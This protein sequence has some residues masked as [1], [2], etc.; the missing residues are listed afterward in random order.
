M[1]GEPSLFN[2]SS[3]KLKEFKVFLF[4]YVDDMVVTRSDEDQVELVMTKLGNEFVGRRL[5]DLSYFLGIYVWKIDEGL[6]LNQ[7][8][9]LVN[10]LKGAEFDNLKPSSTPMLPNQDLFSKEEPISQAKEYRYIIG[11]L[12]YLT[13]TRFN[14]QFA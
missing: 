1:M 9:Y 11:L 4:F 12:Q 8:Q 10:L 7:Q 2:L 6:H 13:L 3:E 14:S 5:G